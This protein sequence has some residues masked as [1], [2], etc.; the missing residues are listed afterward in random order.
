MSPTHVEVTLATSALPEDSQA[1]LMK[2]VSFA[3]R[4]ETKTFEKDTS[5]NADKDMSSDNSVSVMVN[6]PNQLS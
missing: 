6:D 5:Q 2:Q 3:E 4:A 1:L